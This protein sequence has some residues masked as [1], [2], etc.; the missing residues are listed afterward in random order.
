MSDLIDRGIL[1]AEVDR[2]TR[3]NLGLQHAV[4][5]ETESEAEVKRL[6]AL[7]QRAAE[8]I[9]L[10]WADFGTEE[11]CECEVCTAVRKAVGLAAELRAVK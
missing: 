6:K 3:E 9:A 4:H 7:C 2:L 5:S 1:L 10:G 11:G 8:Q